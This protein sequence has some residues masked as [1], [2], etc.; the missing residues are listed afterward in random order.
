[1]YSL[2]QINGQLEPLYTGRATKTMGSQEWR[3]GLPYWVKKTQSTEVL[4]D[5]KKNKF[6]VLSLSNHMTLVWQDLEFEPGEFG[7]RVYTL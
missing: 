3:F 2:V 6:K 4:A 7:L 1:M 5:N